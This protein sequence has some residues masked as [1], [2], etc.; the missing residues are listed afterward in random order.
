MKPAYPWWLVP[1]KQLQKTTCNKR[2]QKKYNRNINFVY[3]APW[4]VIRI[5][6]SWNFLHGI[7]DFG[8]RN[9]ANYEILESR[10]F[11]IWNTLRNLGSKMVSDQLHRLKV[12]IDISYFQVSRVEQANVFQTLEYSFRDRVITTTIDSVMNKIVHFFFFF[13]RQF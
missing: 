6:E 7:M 1:T 12:S 11:E 8:I 4:K 2:K 9:P 10:P 13:F 5:A 3:L